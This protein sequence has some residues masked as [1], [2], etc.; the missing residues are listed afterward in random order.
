[1]DDLQSE[2]S[3]DEITERAVARVTDLVPSSYA[4]VFLHDDED[5][6]SPSASTSGVFERFG[7]EPA[8]ADGESY[9]WTQFAEGSERY[10]PDGTTADVDVPDGTDIRSEFAL[11][12]GSH[13]L[14]VVGSTT[15]GAWSDFDRDVLRAFANVLRTALT[16]QAQ[17]ER[18]DSY[19]DRLV[20]QYGE[21]DERSSHLDLLTDFIDTFDDVTSQ[22]GYLRAI[23]DDFVDSADYQ[24][25]S[26]YPV[27]ADADDAAAVDVA[28]EPQ[29]WRAAETIDVSTPADLGFSAEFLTKPFVTGDVVVEHYQL[30]REDVVTTRTPIDVV[31]VPITYREHRY[32]TLV[33]G[34]DDFDQLTRGEWELLTELVSLVGLSLNTF[35]RVTRRLYTEWQTADVVLGSNSVLSTFVDAFDADVDVTSLTVGP[36][37]ALLAGVRTDM[38]VTQFAARLDDLPWVEPR[39]IDATDVA[40]REIHCTLEFPTT[41]L[42]DRLD[43]LEARAQSL[44]V[45]DDETTLELQFPETDAALE[46]HFA[47]EQLVDLTLTEED[48]DAFDG[49]HIW[50]HLEGE[51]TDRQY[52]ILCRAVEAG[53]YEWPRAKSGKEIATDLDISQPTF[54]HHLRAAERKV[55]E[56]LFS[57][58]TGDEALATEE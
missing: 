48:D 41:S 53:F 15:P 57:L 7:S 18:L 24:F 3:L 5:V 33:L 22:T 31:A 50:E 21:L 51:L 11:P 56:W 12:L 40:A 20:T 36:S 14:L 58:V 42:G 32:G 17:R 27:E 23:C 19:E 44:A 30:S 43:D 10:V 26:F 37:G 25:A 4:A 52:E 45:T 16:M 9:L 6:L 1:V 39:T 38:P 54:H 34:T 2:P 28:S 46:E 49:A 47:G 55:F 35:E 29:V 8:I 13:G